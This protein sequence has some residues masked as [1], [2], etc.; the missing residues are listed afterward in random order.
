MGSD[1]NNDHET[2]SDLENFISCG[3]LCMEDLSKGFSL[4]ISS[5]GRATASEEVSQAILGNMSISGQ[6][7]NHESARLLPDLLKCNQSGVPSMS[8]FGRHRSTSDS[9]NQIYSQYKSEGR[10]D[11][12]EIMME[13]LVLLN[14]NLAVANANPQRQKQN[15]SV[16]QDSAEERSSPRDIATLGEEIRTFRE[17]LADRSR[18]EKESVQLVKDLRDEIASLKNQVLDLKANTNKLTSKKKEQ[19]KQNKKSEEQHSFRRFRRRTK[20]KNKAMGSTTFLSSQSNPTK[21]VQSDNL[22]QRSREIC[23][24]ER[25][26]EREKTP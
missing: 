20:S 9:R 18:T 4:D 14:S 10:L 8:W 5:D 1:Q 3:S 21:T 11:R 24:D 16:F 13:Q 7:E 25:G 2:G 6:E 23:V 22:Y 17:Q 19:K 26:N 15:S 12:M